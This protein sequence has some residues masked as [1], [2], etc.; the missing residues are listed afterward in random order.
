MYS[1]LSGGLVRGRGERDEEQDSLAR[2]SCFHFSST[3]CFAAQ[4][5]TSRLIPFS[6]STS[7]RPQTTQ[8][9]VVELLDAVTEER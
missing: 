8:E 7:L 2:S 6:L 3:V 9:V 1:P 4:D 5:N